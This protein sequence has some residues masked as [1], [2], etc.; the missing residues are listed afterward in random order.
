M[1]ITGTHVSLEAIVAS[2]LED[3]M[4]AA[5][6]SAVVVTALILSSGKPGTGAFLHHG[7]AAIECAA[8][9]MTR[10]RRSRECGSNRIDTERRGASCRAI[11]PSHVDDRCFFDPNKRTARGR[12][13]VAHRA[14]DQATRKAFRRRCARKPSPQNPKII[15][16]HVEGSGTAGTTVSLSLGP[17]DAVSGE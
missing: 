15:I 8:R 9:R 3:E 6:R 2:T 4:C 17:P 1:L 10:M 11:H 13:S 16:A 5:G 12:L 7:S 14:R